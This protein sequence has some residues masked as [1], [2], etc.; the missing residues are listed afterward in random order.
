LED[1]LEPHEVEAHEVP[2]VWEGDFGKK[3]LES[4]LIIPSILQQETNADLEMQEWPPHSV[5]KRIKWYTNL[6]LLAIEEEFNA[7]NVE[8]FR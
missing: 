5:K 3:T 2:E 4:M 8:I 7:L 6:N 1:I